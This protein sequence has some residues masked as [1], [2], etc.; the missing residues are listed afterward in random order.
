MSVFDWALGKENPIAQWGNSNSNTLLGLG[1]SLL[2]PRSDYTALR[3]GKAMDQELGAKKAEAEK[4]AQMLNKTAAYLRAQ[5][6][7]AQFADALENGM[8]DGSTAFKSWLDASKPPPAPDHPAEY[9]LYKLAQSDPAFAEYLKNNGGAAAAESFFGNG[10]PIQNPDGS[11][12]YGQF[13]NRGSFN[14]PELPDGAKFLTP[15][16]QLNTGTEFTGVNKFGAPAGTA[17]PINNEG[18]A[19]DTAIGKV[20]GEA[21]AAATV[22]APKDIAA[23]QAALNVLDQIKNH[24]ALATATGATA[25]LNQFLVGTTRFDF[26]NLVSQAKS[27][28]FLTA[29]EQM[30]GLGALSNA[31][32]QAATAA[33]TRMNTASTKDGFLRALSDYE[34]VVRRGVARAQA[35]VPG[36]VPDAT[37]GDV[38]SLVNKYLTGQ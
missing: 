3:Q 11:V 20:I 32:G 35:K 31:E 15:V 16:Q 30:R 12:A 36:T 33:I 2:S 25:P 24:P 29:I 34:S 1:A 6:G 21:S 27:G 14:V 9:D 17:T 13:G 19:R 22:A 37:G 28:A 38:E 5:P 4:Q 10:V 8:I 26:E 18:A 23:G 7:G